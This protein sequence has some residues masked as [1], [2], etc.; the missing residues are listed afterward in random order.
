M[1]EGNGDRG[2]TTCSAAGYAFEL[3]PVPGMDGTFQVDTP[4]E[5]ITDLTIRFTAERPVKPQKTV[6]RWKVPVVGIHYKWNPD[7]YRHRYLDIMPSCANRI[8]TSA[9][10]VAPVMSLYDMGGTNALTFALSDALHENVLEINLDER[11]FLVC[12]VGLFQAPWLPTREYTC[13]LRLDRRRVPFHVAVGEV[14]D[15]W[16]ASGL[17]RAAAPEAARLPF[18]CTWYSHH[19]EVTQDDVILQAR[20]AKALGMDTIIIDGGWGVP[21][22]PRPAQFPD[23]AGTVKA[24]QALGV[25]VVLWTDPSKPNDSNRGLFPA[26]ML[27]PV[28]SDKGRFDPRFPEIRAQWTREY[29]HLLDGCGCD[30]FKVDFIDSIATAGD[31]DPADPRRDYQSVAEAVDAAMASILA[32]LRERNPE[33]LI[34]Y[35]Q[36]YN[37]PHMLQHCTMMRAVDCSNSY[38]DNR[39]R[40]ADIRLLSGRVPVHSDPITWNMEESVSDAALHVQHTLFS[41]PQLSVRLDALPPSHR[42]MIATYLRFWR[43]HRDVILDGDFTPLEPQNS[44]PAILSRR[45][46]TLLA[47]VFANTVVPLPRDLPRQVII[48]NA[49]DRDRVVLE[50]PADDLPRTVRMTSVVGELG[51]PFGITLKKGVNTLGIPAG[52]YAECSSTAR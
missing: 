14:G 52:A 32:A 41:V 43:A 20:L 30:G 6:L 24:V 46:G 42:A 7:C 47:G 11:G 31:D 33:I 40:I 4:R 35:R 17:K 29:L 44:Y 38:P 13:T 28:G 5:G 22:Q 3:A 26:D 2:M 51:E 18:F 23:L 36:R 37:G 25:K 16:E 50:L 8:A 10:G 19:G 12:S 27:I 39:Q 21:L 15:W 45:G 49:T 48:V 1:A 9:H 34:E